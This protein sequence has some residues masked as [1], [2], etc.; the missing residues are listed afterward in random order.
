MAK[1]VPLCLRMQ[2]LSV[3]HRTRKRIATQTFALLFDLL[4]YLAPLHT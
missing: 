3:H 1:K 2:E 4:S